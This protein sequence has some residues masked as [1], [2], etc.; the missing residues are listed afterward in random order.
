MDTVLAVWTMLCCPWLRFAFVVAGFV[1][2]LAGPAEGLAN[3]P[4]A[5][6]DVDFRRDVRALLS[7]HCFAC[8][9]PD[10]AAREAGLRLDT[11][12]GATADL[13]GYKA[14][15]PGDAAASEVL[16][17]IESDGPATQMPPPESGSL[18]SAEER[19]VIRAW[20][21]AG[22]PY[23]QHWSF[24]PPQ[25]M[26]P[27]S[28]TRQ[29]WV[30]HPLD[31][32][33]LARLEEASLAPAP[34]ADRYRLI[35]RLSFDLTGLPPT[36]AAADA[37]VADDSP[38][39]LEKVVDRLL[40]SQ[41][42]G[43]HWARMW[44]DL[45]R[46]AD[47][48]GYEKDRHRDIWRYRDWVI[49]AFNRDLPY[50]QFTRDQLAGDLRE[51]ATMQQRLA[52]AFHRN[53][54]TN[55]E[56]GTDNE[57]FRIAAVKDRVDTTVQVWMGLTMGCAKC[58]T[59]KFDPIS[60]EDY[61]SVYAF[62]NQTADADRSD[63]APVLPTPT[64]AQ[65]ARLVVLEAELAELQQRLSVAESREANDEVACQA[66]PS[67]DGENAD[68]EAETARGSLEQ[69]IAD[70]QQQITAFR[71]TI[72]QTP[73][74]R[75]L[76]EGKRRESR[77]H[78]RGNF[79]D[80]GATVTPA[81][82]DRF[83]A[84]P[85]DAPRDRLG[86]AEWILQAENPLTA[87]VMVNRVW[88]RLFG[89]GIVETEEDFGSQGTPPTHPE[90]LDWLA[91]DFRE[92]GWSL[93]RLLRTI[94]LSSTYRQAAVMT[95]AKLQR[96]PNN[97]LFSRGPRFRLA[98]ETVRDQAV[99]ASGLATH[100]VGG[101][102]VMPPQPPG[103]WKST[104]NTQSWEDAVGANRYRRGLYTYWKRTSPYPAMTTFDAGSGEVCQIR[105]VRT[106]TPLQAL[107][108]L[109]DDAFLEAA[110]GLARRMAA[111]GEA[112]ERRLARGFRLVLT[113]PPEPAELNRLGEY[114]RAMAKDFASDPEAAAAFL[115]ATR[116]PQKEAAL[117]AT[118]NLL[119]NLDE[120]VMKP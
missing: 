6:A 47:T 72:P 92:Q 87:R 69:A 23:D 106:N 43:E 38:D 95:D 104:Y 93:K 101:P 98:A 108:T 37:F 89:I 113:R 73:I 78:I 70:K 34:E 53:T 2:M 110:G 27:P 68:D 119:L 88:A 26:P 120:T 112:I 21:T 54:M 85:D 58:H 19:Q 111:A 46:Y 42:F 75:E 71:K 109:N 45:A 9:G 52:T 39:A 96:D 60:Q 76:S 82:P 84:F 14:I 32:F 11:T 22:A 102:S 105:R 30:R 50:D 100:R 41:A 12:A 4:D 114:Y 80:P 24:V 62:F 17:R 117:V 83:G 40:A 63:D 59:H 55:D 90:L 67:S 36:P 79:L 1:G 44:L 103:V 35:R 7:K 97:R 18:L 8:H 77:V 66:A 25:Q 65:A 29:D 57:E 56:G 94:V 64:A 15:V 116:S 99:V 74:L 51:S 28:V 48:K 10:E 33:V 3:D 81:V 16:H 20:I 49:G 5:A 61:Y 86:L 107:V 115:E 91:V 13:G 118:A 31:A